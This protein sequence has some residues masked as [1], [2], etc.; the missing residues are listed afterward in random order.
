MEIHVKYY[1]EK[2]ETQDDGL[3]IANIIIRAKY[4][5]FAHIPVYVVPCEGT[6]E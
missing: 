6:G 1:P 3:E 2:E 5:E 4:T